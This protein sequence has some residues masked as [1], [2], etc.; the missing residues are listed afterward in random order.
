MATDSVVR[1]WLFRD[2]DLSA[3]KTELAQAPLGMRQQMTVDAFLQSL[4]RIATA[5]AQ[6]HADGLGLDV[7]PGEL[8]ALGELEDGDSDADVTVWHDDMTCI[9][10][11]AAKV[12]KASTG[13]WC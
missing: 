9:F 13:A 1:K 11:A 8:T 3:A 7:P 2:K 5:N 12:G 6:S 10:C 4:F